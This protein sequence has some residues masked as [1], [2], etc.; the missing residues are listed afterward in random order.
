MPDIK[1]I[2]ATIE[3]RDDGA[4]LKVVFDG[5]EDLEECRQFIK[6]LRETTSVFSGQETL[7]AH[8]T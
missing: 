7:E 5:I 8:Q 2:A 3:L 6:K 1:V 4:K